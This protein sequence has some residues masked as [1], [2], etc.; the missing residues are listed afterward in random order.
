MEKN[1]PKMLSHT[2][3]NVDTTNLKSKIISF[4]S[5]FEINSVFYKQ[6][7]CYRFLDFSWQL[8]FCY[9]LQVHW[10]AL[11]GEYMHVMFIIEQY[12]VT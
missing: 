6:W 1:I 9:D 3:N 12:P 2:L 11:H 8:N 5:I 10:K 7:F 4:H